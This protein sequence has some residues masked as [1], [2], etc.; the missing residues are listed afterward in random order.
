MND[1]TNLT[2]LEFDN[3]SSHVQ[4]LTALNDLHVKQDE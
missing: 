4:H 1:Y 3:K 2:I